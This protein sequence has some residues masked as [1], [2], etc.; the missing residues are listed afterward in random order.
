MIREKIYKF[1]HSSLWI[2]S[3]GITLLLFIFN[4]LY[5]SDITYD[6]WEKAT[7]KSDVISA[8]IMLLIALALIICGSFFK[9]VIEKIN[10][11]KLFFFFALLYTAMALYLILNVNTSL[12]ADPFQVRT[13][14]INYTEEFYADFEIGGY[15]S[16]YPHQLGLLTYDTILLKFSANTQINFF[17]N[18]FFVL[19]INYLTYK[20]S[21]HLFGNRAVNLL[22]ILLSFAF[23]PQLLFI[24]FA[25]GL[26]PGLFFMMLAFYS[27]LKFS[28]DYKW[29]YLPGLV[30]GASCAILMK[31]NYLIGV[32][33]ILIFLALKMLK[34]RFHWKNLTAAILLVLTLFLPQRILV[35]YYEGVTGQE[36]DNG[37][38][39]ILW[40]AM[41][42]DMDNHMRAAGWYDGTN[43]NIYTDSGYNQ[44]IA[45]QMGEEKLRENW[46]EIKAN[47]SYALNYFT[48]KNLTQWCDP[49]YQSCFVAVPSD[50]ILMEYPEP[51]QSLYEPG[52]V[53]N[54]IS[55]FSKFVTILIWLFAAVFFLFFR[56]KCVGWEMLI[57]FTLGGFLFH[58]FWEAKSQ[59]VYPYLFV[60]IPL[61]AYAIMKTIGGI[62]RIKREWNRNKIK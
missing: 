24:L 25:Y 20:I 37:S 18:F 44:E 46:A 55:V 50:E 48:E 16:R 4:F 32:L 6:T 21:D 38:P 15:I 17:A 28:V 39:T 29:R 14:A 35:S 42:T 41:G 27:A 1:L 22:T 7:V 61:A 36:L 45:Q 3:C 8:L 58:T 31:N 5:H 10:E 11:K 2:L 51:L 33:A 43:W 56:K 13:A 23:L 40:L 49:M 53:E 9:K 30:F 54:H 52:A 57:C 12:G 60:L 34:E 62:N 47:P 19:G 26:T 59:Y